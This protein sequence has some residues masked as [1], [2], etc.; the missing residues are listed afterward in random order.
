MSGGSGSID[1]S[2]SAEGMVKIVEE[3]NMESSGR[4]LYYTGTPMEWW[5]G[6]PSFLAVCLSNKVGTERLRTIC[7]TVTT[8]RVP[9][10]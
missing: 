9:H 1:L 4:F 5:V 2:E 8:P 7:V 3:L 6:I 10:P